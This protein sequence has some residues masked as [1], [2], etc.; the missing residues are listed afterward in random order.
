MSTP[1]ICQ[2]ALQWALRQLSFKDFLALFQVVPSLKNVVTRGGF[3]LNPK[4]YH[5]ENTK[6]RIL[7][8]LVRRQDLAQSVMNVLARTRQEAEALPG[9]KLDSPTSYKWLEEHWRE[10]FVEMGDARPLGVAFYR[11]STHP[12]L[13]RLG[14]LLMKTPTF[15]ETGKVEPSGKNAATNRAKQGLLDVLEEQLSQKENAQQP[16]AAPVLTQPV[17]PGLLSE[18]DAKGY[19]QGTLPGLLPLTKPTPAPA[20]APVQEAP[21]VVAE[22]APVLSIPA[23]EVVVEPA[24][25]SAEAAETVPE[26]SAEAV[27][28]VS[29]SRE[30]EKLRGELAQA[31]KRNVEL[32]NE[33]GKLQ[34]ESRKARESSEKALRQKTEELESLRKEYQ[35]IREDFED[36]IDDMRD[37]FMQTQK[38]QMASFY[39]ETLGIHPDQL[40]TLY[41]SQ[42]ATQN[43][44]ERVKKTLAKQRELDKKHGTIQKLRS[45]ESK[46]DQLLTDVREALEDALVVVPGLTDLEKELEQRLLE[47]RGQLRKVADDGENSLSGILPRIVG[48]VKELPVHDASSQERLT[49][50]ETLLASPLG[51]GLFA[52]DEVK[53]I[54]DV[55]VERRK[56]V[57]GALQ[58][59]AGIEVPP[60]GIVPEQGVRMAPI[61]RIS[62][63][64]D[65]L[66][67]TEVLVDAYNVIKTDP[68][69]SVKEKSANGFQAVRTE[70]VGRCKKKA[71]FFKKVTLVFD[72]DLPTDNV[73]HIADN[74]TVIYAA[75]KSLDQ[76]ADNWIVNKM[77]ELDAKDGGASETQRWVVSNDYGLLARV[78]E[79]CDGAVDNATFLAFLG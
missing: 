17:L 18:V 74:F 57:E 45:E 44:F 62:W 54:Q 64:L 31:R 60:E 53:S 46:F 70:F 79:L 61:H 49:D 41:E 68:I 75:K 15:W 26:T 67:N 47:I 51:R 58:V 14:D 55:V 7:A 52:P 3:T 28:P 6:K 42:G 10:K 2:E 9:G 23:T 20:P 30:I 8:T 25:A 56:F 29:S 36:A 1:A 24:V 27:A 78:G 77:I 13:G 19:T 22:E 4:N 35:G 37:E 63:Y 33:N 43:L 39:A 40:S 50:V 65:Q 72:G 16:Q 73:N 71:K 66:Q 11:D 12:V 38:E 32:S 21:A 76:N 59:T 48:Y 69:M 5:Q 34:K